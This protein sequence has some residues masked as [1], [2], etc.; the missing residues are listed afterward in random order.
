MNYFSNRLPGRSRG[1]RD[2]FGSV[3]E[4]I[5]LISSDARRSLA[6]EI[7]SPVF[8]VP[9]LRFFSLQKSDPAAP[10]T[11]PLTDLMGENE[12]FSDTAALVANLDLVISVDTAVVHLAAALGKPVWLL[13]RFDPDWRWL[14]GRCDSPWY[15]TLRVYRQPHPGARDRVIAEVVRDL[16]DFSGKSDLVTRAGLDQAAE[17]PRPP[18]R[19]ST[20]AHLLVADPHHDR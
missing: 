12:D 15:P 19:C 9:G 10:E 8:D 20:P 1:R 7:L 11:F 14:A 2:F 17:H 4:R 18:N 3:S 16:R 13:D 5:A 6:R